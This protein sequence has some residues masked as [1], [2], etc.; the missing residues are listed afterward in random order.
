MRRVVL[1]TGASSGIGAGAA[2]LLAG[3][4]WDVALHYGGNRAGAEAVAADCGAVGARTVLLPADLGDPAAVETLFSGFDAAFPRLDAMVVNAGIVDVPAR[5]TEMSA[6]RLVRM[7]TVNTVSAI[8][9]AGQAGRRLS[10]AAGGPGGAIVLVSSVAVRLGSGGQ[11]AD[12]AAS[13]AALDTLAK[14]MSDEMAP[15]GVRVVSLRPGVIDTEIHAKGGNPDRA[16]R[17]ASA[18]PM[19]RPGR[20]DEVAE[21]IRW[22]VEDAT[23]VTGT[24]IEVTGGR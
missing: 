7:F 22:L 23:Y 1:I 9:C 12:Y 14:G 16:A 11:Y 4:G 19:R 5:V 2:R 21:A 15:E 20:V 3:R 17:L 24:T 13:K 10:T 8:L 6:A 18:I